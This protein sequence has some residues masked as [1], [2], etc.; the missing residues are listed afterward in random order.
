MKVRC[1]CDK[2]TFLE[3]N[4]FD[5][6]DYTIRQTCRPLHNVTGYAPG[7]SASEPVFGQPLNGHG[8]GCVR[9][10]VGIYSVEDASGLVLE[11]RQ[12]QAAVNT[13]RNSVG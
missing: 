8:A 10:S 4:N 1:G 7:G 12:Y 5:I 11:Y 13:L 6:G 3:C 9:Q 2:N